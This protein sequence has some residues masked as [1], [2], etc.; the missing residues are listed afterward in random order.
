MN[1]SAVDIELFEKTN[2]SLSSGKLGIFRNINYLLLLLFSA[3]SY[4]H[5]TD[6]LGVILFQQNIRR[7]RKLSLSALKKT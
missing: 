6:N 4:L 3:P 7:P 5:L 1:L 2:C